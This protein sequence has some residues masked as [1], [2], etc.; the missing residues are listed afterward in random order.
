MKISKFALV[1]FHYLILA[2]ALARAVA[3][4]LQGECRSDG[5]CDAVDAE[6]LP[7]P[8]GDARRRITSN[9]EDKEPECG[10]WASEGECENNPSYMLRE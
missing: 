9:C 4:E 8:D 5:S 10:L 6:A 3:E 1:L 2:G 7:A